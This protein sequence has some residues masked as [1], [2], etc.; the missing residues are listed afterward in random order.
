MS[1]PEHVLDTECYRNYW[2][3]L[4]ESGLDVEMWNGQHYVAERPVDAYAWRNALFQG[5]QASTHVTF[6]GTGYDMPLVTMAMEGATAEQL[7]NASDAIIVQGLKPWEIARVPDWIDHIDLFDVAPGQGSLKAYAA[8][9]H[10]RRLQDLPIEP[11]AM[12]G[13][14]ARQALRE[15][16]RLGD[17]P[18]TRDLFNTFPTQL[19]L[20]R[21]MSAEYG[22]DLRSK[23][24]A[25]IAEAVM[26]A[27]LPFKVQ[28]PAVAYGSKFHYRPPEWLQVPEIADLLALLARNPFTISD[29]GSPV[30][31]EELEN[32]LIA[33]GDN[34][35]QM[36]SGGLH[37]TEKR[38]MHVADAANI[39]SDHDV[40]S[41]YPSLIIRTGIY[42]QQI[43]PIFLDIY[44]DWYD[45]RLTAKRRATALKAELKELKKQLAA[46]PND[47]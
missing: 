1:K 41:Y 44:R 26:K 32:S 23:S 15:Y 27:L 2:L 19:D 14:A 10:S 12:I 34:A 22:V 47:V 39:I 29:S 11:S 37:S 38:V 35:Y 16:C 43:G 17:L 18:A 5:L 42:P 6:N 45:R 20:R 30:M 36:G 21:D 33:I 13:P 3:C 24:D 9:M 4:S 46:L 8:K 28:R 31:T 40:A 7:K 25:Q